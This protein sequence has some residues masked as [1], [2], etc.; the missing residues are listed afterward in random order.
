[1][2]SKVSETLEKEPRGPTPA[3]PAPGESRGESGT[4]PT[5]E[6]D[7]SDLL[8]SVPERVRQLLASIAWF[9]AARVEHLRVE[10]K[11]VAWLALLGVVGMMALVAAVVVGTVLLALGVERTLEDQVGLSRGISACLTGGTFFLLPFA[12]LLVAFRAALTR[13]LRQAAERISLKE[14]R[15]AA[16]QESKA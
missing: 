6:P 15:L 16:E 13:S 5:G 3:S 8:A 7:P 10:V 14:T 12:G 9:A 11:R 2:S 4:G 1:M